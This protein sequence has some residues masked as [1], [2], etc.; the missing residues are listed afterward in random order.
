MKIGLL[1]LVFVV[2]FSLVWMGLIEADAVVDWNA[3]AAQAS[4]GS[5]HGRPGFRRQVDQPS[6][7]ER[8]PFRRMSDH[9]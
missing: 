8:P 5:G 4:A 2:L 1:K 6:G 3:I 7:H 9:F